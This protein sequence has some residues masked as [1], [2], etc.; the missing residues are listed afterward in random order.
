MSRP[1]DPFS[2]EGESR[3]ANAAPDIRPPANVAPYVAALGYEGVMDFLLEFGGA[4]MAFSTSPKSWSLLSWTIG[5]EAAARLA[6]ALG[7]VKRRVPLAGHWL[8]RML[9]RQGLSVAEIA[10]RLRRSDVAVRR[11]LKDGRVR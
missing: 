9:D 10:R 4:E 3:P 2:S 11:W 1:P 5:P 8:A 6:D 7:P